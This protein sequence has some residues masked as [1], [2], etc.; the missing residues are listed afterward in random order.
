MQDCR[1]DDYRQCQP[2]YML[3][4]VSSRTF[5]RV[6]DSVDSE[7]AE[8]PQMHVAVKADGK[9][10]S[11]DS[12]G[13]T[14]V[15]CIV[16][17]KYIAVANVGDS[18]AV[19]GHRQDSLPEV[20]KVSSPFPYPS[21]R[22]GPGGCLAAVALSYDHK[23]YVRGEW[24]RAIAAGAKIVASGRTEKDGEAGE[25]DDLEPVEGRQYQVFTPRKDKTKLS[26]SRAFGDFHLKQNDSL[27]PDRQAVIAV[28]ELHIRERSARYAL[29][30]AYTIYERFYI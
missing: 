20:S 12:S 27:P 13:S 17:P 21:P 6:S 10:E 5:F 29:I 1:Y 8:R 30:I 24:D 19:L 14:G 22:D 18:R 7:L 16:T 23:L 4:C 9:L 3:G 15:L 26:M 25:G 28:P 11:Y 2:A